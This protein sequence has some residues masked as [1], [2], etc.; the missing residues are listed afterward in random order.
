MAFT[1]SKLAET[2]VGAGGAS[3][4]NFNNIPQNYTDLVVKCSLRDNFASASVNAGIQLNGTATN[5]T[6]RAVF[7]TGTTANSTT[8]TNSYL[9]TVGT[10]GTAN[11]FASNEFYIP[12]YTSSNFKSI[13]SDA[14]AESNTATVYMQMVAGLWSNVSAINQ[15]TV[16]PLNATL[17]TQYSTA[18]LYGVRIEL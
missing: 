18:T 9:Y 6:G 17:F 15:I 13:S 14:V 1:Y 5:F 2:T 8:V 3:A 12:N 4:I 16:Y 7:G 10:S 11:T